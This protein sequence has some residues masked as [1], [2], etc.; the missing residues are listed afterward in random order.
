MGVIFPLAAP[1]AASL[2]G[3]DLGFVKNCFGAIL[4][5][6][7]WGNICSPIADTTIMTVLATKCPLPAHVSAITQ[8]ASL[9]GAIA[10]AA[11]VLLSLG[12]VGPGGALLTGLAMVG[13]A[14]TRF[15]PEPAAKGV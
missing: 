15:R 2:S 10:L 7:L 8:Y 4:G 11:N 9:A 1:L 6:S 13:V 5:S 12:V 14:A 3:G